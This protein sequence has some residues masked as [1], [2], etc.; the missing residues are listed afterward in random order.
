MPKQQAVLI[1]GA[2]RGIG[3]TTALHLAQRGHLV[4]ATGRAPELLESLAM[5]AKTGHLPLTVAALDVRDP[6]AVEE[7]ISRAVADFG[8][9]DVLVNNAGYGITGT[10]EELS[11]REMHEV[12]ETNFFAAVHLAQVALP[13]M[14]RQHWGTIVNVGSVAGLIGLPMEGAYAA[15]KFAMRAMSRSMRLEVAP[16]GVRVVLIEPGLV[17]T[18]FHANKAIGQRVMAGDS[19][20]EALRG[21]AAMRSTARTMFGE[22]PARTAMRIQHVI[23]ARAPGARYTVGWDA[24][25]GAWAA[26][27]LPDAVLD[28]FLRKA[29]MGR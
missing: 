6:K 11:Q 8:R 3:R 27:V 5:E 12:F 23:E 26:R 14:R 24:W 4:L 19:P 7:G 28:F 29:I 20:Y 2:T 10:Y 13:H 22:Q 15:T 17:R 25:A 16:F 18:D 9:L 1:T 21:M